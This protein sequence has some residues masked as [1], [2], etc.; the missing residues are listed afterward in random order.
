M[1]MSD[2]GHIPTVDRRHPSAQRRGV[3][4]PH[5]AIPLKGTQ[6]NMKKTTMLLRALAAS[7]AL[8]PA[9]ALSYETTVFATGL[10]G[11]VKIDLTRQGNLLVTEQGTANNDGEL[12][13]IDRDGSVQTILS[14]LPSGIETTGSRS[15]PQ[16]PVVDGCC[17]VQLTI[18]EGDMLRFDPA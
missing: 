8:A 10:T 15:G 6:S 12:S 16:S 4:G 1:N 5:Q 3:Y 7:L 18:G 14:G 13:R 2:I 11:P 17:V 9:I